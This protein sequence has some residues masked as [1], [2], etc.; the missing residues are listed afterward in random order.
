MTEDTLTS[1][2]MLADVM[3][4]PEFNALPFQERK[5]VVERG[6]SE[7]AQWLQKERGG[8]TPETWQE[9]GDTAQAVRQSVTESETFLEKTGAALKQ[10]GGAVKDALAITGAQVVGLSPVLP[11]PAGGLTYQ[12]PGETLGPM[13]LNRSGALVGG[14]AETLMN[15]ETPMR[16][17]IATVKQGLDSGAFFK[18]K[19]GLS[20]YLD[21]A[22]GALQQAAGQYHGFK[23]QTQQNSVLQDAENAKLVAAY[24]TARDPETWAALEKRL[25]R[26]PFDVAVQE[27]RQRLQNESKLGQ[28]LTA[29]T[30]P[31][32]GEAADPA[33][34][35]G[36]LV[37]VGMGANVLRRGVSAG[38]RVRQI[39]TGLGAEMLS[40][41]ISATMEDPRLSLAER[42]QVAKDSI[43]SAAG[44][45]GAGAL[46]VAAVRA[47]DALRGRTSSAQTVDQTMPT[48]A[49]DP[50]AQESIG[51]LTV[52]EAR[53]LTPRQP[54][55]TNVPDRVPAN[56]PVST[57]PP[58]DQTVP[59]A[60]PTP[61]QTFT[62]SNVQTGTAMPVPPPTAAAGAGAGGIL[63]EAQV[64]SSGKP[65][66]AAVETTVDFVEATDL[67]PL[68]Q[69]EVN[70]D[71]TR[72]RANNRGSAEQV[73][74]IAVAPDPQLLGVS[75][76]SSIGAPVVDDVV[77]AGNGRAEGL[78]KGYTDNT[79]GMQRY[80]SSIE[81]QA[82]QMGRDIS[83]MRQ[84]VMIRRVQRYVSGDRRSFVR[85]S[86]P[87]YA[88][89]Q[90]TTAEAA[91][92][93]A[94]ALGDLSRLEFNE[95]GT[96]TSAAAQ[97]VAIK[98]KEAQRGVNATTGGKPDVVE[99]TR[100]VQ[101]A[102][103]ATLARQNNVDV[104]DLS[105]FLETDTGRRVLVEF[106]RAAPGL[107]ALD[108]DL[109]LGDVLLPA[110]TVFNQGAQA[111]QQRKFANINEWATNRNRELIRESLPVEAEAL[112]EVMVAAT[113]KP[114][115][116]RELFESYLEAANNEQQ[117]RQLSRG[118]AD[119]FGE[120]R[121][122][123]AGRRI[124]ARVM[125]D[126][127]DAATANPQGG[128]G[129]A[130]GEGITRPINPTANRLTTTPAPVS[131]A[132]G[133]DVPQEQA[134]A[135][136]TG[137]GS[138]SD[139]PQGAQGFKNLDTSGRTAGFLNTEILA[140]ARQ[141]IADGFTTFANWSQAMVTRFGRAI[142]EFLAGIWEQI[143]SPQTNAAQNVRLGMPQGTAPV[144][145]GAGGFVGTG[146]P[147]AESQG[148]NVT[149]ARFAPPNE[150][151]QTISGR[152]DADV[153]S[154][155]QAWLAG[156][157]TTAAVN[158]LEA[159][160]AGLPGDTKQ[161]AMGLLINQLSQTVTQGD[162][163]QQILLRTLLERMSRVWVAESNSADVARELR[164]RAVVNNAD[165][166]PVSAILAT[167]QIL[168]DR[169]KRVLG[170]R[171]TGGEEALLEKIKQLLLQKQGDI[172]DRVEA[173]L[174]TVMGAMLRP[175][176]TLQQAVNALL[177]GKTQR[178]QII[179]DVAR[180]L[181]QR[182][183]QRQVTPERQT[184]LAALVASL[185][186]TLGAA[187]Q[188][189]PNAPA[190]LS[191][192]ELLARTF[193]DS[194][195]EAPLFREAWNAG[196]EQVRGMLIELGMT[197][198][199]AD[200]RL[201]EL[202]PPTPAVAYAPGMVKQAILRG[203]QAAGYGADRATGTG[204]REVDMRAEVLQN[205]QRAMQAVMKVWDEEAA[206]AGVSAEA[207]ARGR[208]LAQQALTETLQQWQEQRQKQEA[209]AELAA[210]Q[211]ILAK[212]SPA[213]VKLLNDLRNKIA[214]GMTWTE[215][216]TDMPDTQKD[217]QRE[218]YRRLMLDERLEDL[219]LEERVALTNEL[220]KAWQRERRT[221]FQRE[222][223][224]VGVLGEKKAS[225]RQK[226]VNGL[227]KLLRLMNLGVLTADTV[228][229]ALMGE[230]GLRTLS[231][232]DVK[233]LRSMAEAAYQLPEGSLRNRALQEMLKE[234]Q[235][236]TGSSR[237]EILSNLWT[238]SVLSGLRTQFDT[239]LSVI[240]GMGANLM[241]AA[242]LMGRGQGAAAVQAHAQWWR[243]LI[244][245]VRESGQILLRGDQSYLKKFG[246]SLQDALQGERTGAVPVGEMLWRNGNVWQK[247]F[248]A[249]VML[250][251]G[252]LMAAADHINNT[253]TTGGA[254]AV[255]RA[256][257]P[258]LYE[259]RVA[260]TAAERAAARKQAT[261]EVTGGDAPTTAEERAQISVRTREILSGTMRP[262]DVQAASEVG[263][264]AA[265]QND[266]TGLFGTVYH[267]MKG[268]LGTVQRGLGEVAEDE[269]ASRFA[270]AVSA[271][272]GATLHGLT[273]TRFMRFG[274]NFGADLTRYM[275]GT[276]LLGKAGF[277][278]RNVSRMQQELLL[279]KNVVG[280]MLGST[281][282]AMF[283]SK[284]DEEEGWHIEGDWSTLTPQQQKQRMT[285]GLERMTMWKRENGQVQRVSYKQWP[286]MSLFAMVGR[287]LDEKRHKPEIW[288]QRGVAGHLLAATLTGV[289]QIQNVSAMQN[290]AQIFGQ[291][292]FAG[293]PAAEW[294]ERLIK[295]PV[296]Y[297]GGLVPT[298][299]KD[300]EIWNDPRSYKPEGAVELLMRNMPVA[301]RFVN[302][303]RPQLNQLGEEVKLQR[304]PWSRAYTSVESAD[305]HR[306]LGALLARGLTLPAASDEALITVNGVR[307]P[308]EALGREAVW[309]YEK[310]VGEGYR[311]WL[312]SPDGQ[313]LL[314]MPVQQ[315]ERVINLRSQTIK[316]QA[317][318]R[319]GY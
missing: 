188:G 302:D 172:T 8:W 212:D 62:G 184:A 43:I 103:L 312:A 216:F 83:T 121:T 289:F 281:L 242:V 54:I 108:V 295:M 304:A 314:T 78:I 72:D 157:A 247:Y 98:F 183:K 82:A 253:A 249:P 211:K 266:P 301:R 287:M 137:T 207:W 150:V 63:G 68:L 178:E 169:G 306:V 9:F 204:Q 155:A 5:Q 185:K 19:G 227:P 94:E 282:A 74:R 239:F 265:F 259:G 33:E 254:L 205:P 163:A 194:V 118:S 283:L 22:D 255:A 40:E 88:A 146:S 127:L 34:A 17:A 77:L 106:T 296:N 12:V 241:Q 252:R 120:T 42:A 36:N 119:I 260:F 89:L 123:Q 271:A 300:A 30:R 215:I 257:N 199:D 264:M 60:V 64:V 160:T 44:L 85:E 276:Y 111:V 116:L 51:D 200:T 275:P 86:N 45:M 235:A 234:M 52:D 218:I 112:I 203:M 81:Q 29:E 56:A 87:K 90:E 222:L 161:R 273:G 70:A 248:M 26:T 113:R 164:Q 75:P 190:S 279:G 71:Q 269:T 177:G 245:G 270:R 217:R 220:D 233:R 47:V 20:E 299:V 48:T 39:G 128:D 232:A 187:V 41:Q 61:P 35:A 262:E 317:K 176:V 114:S 135:N 140:E 139:L 174:N 7:S 15:D 50:L 231:A 307:A 225:D 290:L 288:A 293:D 298:L 141:L 149:Q 309:R 250:F 154:E 272:L 124:L 208:V 277:Y 202:M 261:I 284:D 175:R 122:D 28:A 147:G 102:A 73:A 171:F 117:Q 25:M 173:I 156:R 219:T 226:V 131:T 66:G 291:P 213:L 165:L 99:A 179:D 286:T 315:A 130:S 148:A 251:T 142:R 59:D 145:V 206:A 210:K 95:S 193:V 57:P 229:E 236:K 240:N 104:S 84:P 159:G 195:A 201:N 136:E 256:L 238:A 170:A 13:F 214:P 49:N 2:A 243:F 23:D 4:T 58:A 230:F 267:A 93:D 180:A 258:E 91:L 110:L 182:A 31:L 311:A 101:L 79:P 1:P 151:D 10:A 96:L 308:I 313:A 107:A 46:P 192:G 53:A 24:L 162:E 143:T 67:A 144:T 246:E 274:F 310:A 191:F 18:A 6:L 115:I 186:R 92:L 167:L 224:K 27:D 105:A 11:T 16:T 168:V 3:S 319:V 221:V 69:R 32:I 166:V 268:A 109:G 65:D 294:G 152:A 223:Q 76:V 318:V 125:A 209:K 129:Q 228:R 132:T 80:R 14:V 133:L 37:G 198:A 38:Q 138:S 158:A 97:Q 280:L 21:L 196:R 100:R 292:T 189:K 181:M 316:R 55:L 263:D 197:E 285:A 153:L 278:G 297:V 303:G 126:Q 237:M 134:N 244:D 305:A